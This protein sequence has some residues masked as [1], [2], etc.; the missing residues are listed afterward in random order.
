M[1]MPEKGFLIAIGIV[2]IFML[3][4]MIILAIWMRNR[5]SAYDFFRV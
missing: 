1:S 4:W 5:E 2:F 3:T